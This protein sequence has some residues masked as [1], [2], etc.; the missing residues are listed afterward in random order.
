MFLFLVQYFGGE[1]SGMEETKIP[2][3]SI[4]A[5]LQYWRGKM[6]LKHFK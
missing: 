4:L 3:H 6:G 1:G 5:L 2:P